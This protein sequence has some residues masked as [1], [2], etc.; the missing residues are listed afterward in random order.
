MNIGG[1]RGRGR[2]KKRWLIKYENYMR[3]VGMRV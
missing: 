3:V 1:K 2:R